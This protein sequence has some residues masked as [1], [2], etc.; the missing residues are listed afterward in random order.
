MKERNYGID[1]L[2]IFGMFLICVL[3]ICGQGQA[4]LRVSGF[5]GSYYAAWFLETLAYCAVDIYGLVSGYV[6]VDGKSRPSRLL[7][8]W[9]RVFWYSALG[10]FLAVYVFHFN[11]LEKMPWKALFPVGWK[12]YWYFSAYVGVF[13]LAPWLNRLVLALKEKERR[14]LLA[15]LFLFFTVGT[16]I[17]RV[18]ETGSD[19]L[20]LAGGYTFVWLSILY[21]M[22]ACLKKIKLKE[23]GPFFYL[24]V[25]FCSTAF[26][27]LFKILM[28]NYTLAVRGKAYY[29][30]V[31][32]GYTSPTMV[33]NAICLL[34]LFKDIKLK[35]KWS[36]D[37]VSFFA[38][39]AFSVYLVQVQPYVWEYILKGICHDYYRSGP[40]LILL[41][42]LGAAAALYAV[43]TGVDII[44]MLVFR[45]LRVRS[46]CDKICAFVQDTF[47]GMFERLT[48]G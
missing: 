47:G 8:L 21:V 39:L 35:R 32:T 40:F 33:I 15:C 17:P 31:F 37:L 23:H 22:G 46:L 2:R 30:R 7:E 9:M 41:K 27:W 14:K 1:L 38:P 11:S 18:A 6:G 28:E 48:G 44:R 12:T 45:L 5:S 24:S 36:K 19:Y 20:G 42:I 3:H 16:M 43:C 4:M 25:C 29:G 26:S 13:I 10:S 34:L